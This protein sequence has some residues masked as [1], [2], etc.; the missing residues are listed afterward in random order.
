MKKKLVF[1]FPPRL[2]KKPLTY[3]LV[4]DYDLV[5]NI[6]RAKIEE[7]E[8]G[9]LVVELQGPRANFEAGVEFVRSLGVDVQQLAK[10]ITLSRERCVDCGACVG[11]C[12][13]EALYLGDDAR[14]VFEPE[15][16][17]L[18][19]SCVRACPTRAIALEI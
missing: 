12:P 19:E 14:L 15:K 1:T 16:C 4:K 18:C 5:V 9:V 11:V 10:D 17:I 3:H 7:G 8:T 2:S 13:P 6:I